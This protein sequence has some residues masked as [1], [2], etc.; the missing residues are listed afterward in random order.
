M[1]STT[2][3][4]SG[5]R[6]GAR[7]GTST[8][9]STPPASPSPSPPDLLPILQKAFPLVTSY[10]IVGSVTQANAQGFKVQL[11]YKEE[12]QEEEEKRAQPHGPSQVF[13]KQVIASDYVSTKKDWPDL[14]R[15]LM[16]ARTEVRLYAEL[17]PMMRERGF[18]SIPHAYLAECDLNGWVDDHERATA[19]VN[20]NIDHYGLPDPTDKGGVIVLECISE[21]THFQ[22]SPLSVSQCQ[23]CL[24]AVAAMHA[25]AWQDVALLET[26]A[27]RLSQASFHLATRNPK[28]LVG[29][30][31]A[32]QQFSAAFAEPLLQANLATDRMQQLGHRVARHA[33]YISDQV[34]PGPKDSKATLVHGDYKSM[35]VFLPHDVVNGTTLLV[36][37]AST[38]VGLGMS[39]VAMHLH[40]AV[41]P[42]DLANGGEEAL[43]KY[44]WKTL[45]DLLNQQ[46]P[47]ECYQYSYN[48][49]WRDYRY[50]VV[51]YFRFFL[52]RFWKTAT[53]ESMQLKA[54]SK[55]TN[56]V[57]RSVPAAMA[58]VA[59][60]DQYLAEIEQ[61]LD[62]ST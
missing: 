61:E 26:A 25:A 18:Q 4:V 44:Y 59:R 30:V 50:A 29:M 11:I 36:D 39:D 55:N 58:F 19:P 14:R 49:A 37:Y 9:T 24:A 33:K 48:E 22:D 47:D 21:A 53:P 10:G 6:T 8:S 28:E 17:F 57:N 3:S 7:T 60:V 16:Y 20:P 43:V 35:N 1:T 38:G 52:G 42:Q 2:S 5:T 45:Q 54:D 13:V 40:H 12:E 41:L 27:S 15:T 62:Q 51:D 46:Y 32:W 31:D 23:Q 34:S 56:L